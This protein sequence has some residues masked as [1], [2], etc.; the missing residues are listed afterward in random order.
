MLKY[1]CLVLDHDDTVVQ[2]E[3]TVN[4]PCFCR[5]L[6]QYHP[7]TVYPLSEYIADCSKMSFTEMCKIRFGMD[8]AEL[9]QEYQFW[10]DYAREH[11]PE[12][13]PGMKELLHR[14]RKAG[15]KICVVSMSSRDSI[16]RDYRTHYDLE[17]DV[18]YSWELPEDKRKPS[19][20]SL[21][22]IRKEFG[23]KPEEM[24]VVDDMKFAVGMARAAQSPI[25]FAAWGR[26]SFP[27]VCRE[28]ESL[29]DFTFYTVKAF[30]NFLFD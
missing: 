19:P 27:E 7:G 21:A 22:Q 29:C 12:P 2:S 5:Y 14:Y 15:G 23:L 1:R 8:E 16:L 4:Y 9:K 18:I 24:L 28:M 10:Q 13:F 17:P 11:I 6:E 20:W 3:A 30:E 26:Q 25:A